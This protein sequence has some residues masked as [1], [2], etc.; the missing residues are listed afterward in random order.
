M[1]AFWVVSGWCCPIERMNFYVNETDTVSNQFLCP[2]DG[3]KI[4]ERQARVV[5]G[6]VLA[7]T[8]LYLLTN[9]LIFPLLLVVDFS[10]RGF[11]KP[12]FSLLGRLAGDLVKRLK[13][14]Y[15]AT[16]QAPKR[17]A[18][19]IG[20]VF[21][22]LISVLH[23]LGIPTLIPTGVLAGFAALESLAGFCAGCYVYTFYIRLFPSAA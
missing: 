2:T 13:L 15:T 6:L 8:F 17:F 21:A 10:L 12:R 1:T 14:G 3:V 23:L 9:W 16:D 7:T 5:A 20:L 22:L 18:A 19:R 11:G 4:N